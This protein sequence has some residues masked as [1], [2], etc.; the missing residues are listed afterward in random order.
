MLHDMNYDGLC[1]GL[2]LCSY[3][4]C[5]PSDGKEEPFYGVSPLFIDMPLLVFVTA[6]QDTGCYELACFDISHHV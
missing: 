3:G 5:H 1:I 2:Q 4:G 6:S